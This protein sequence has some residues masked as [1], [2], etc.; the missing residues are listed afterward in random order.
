LIY[1][2]DQ[3][4]GHYHEAIALVRNTT[5]SWKTVYGQ[6]SI[7]EAV[8]LVGTADSNYVTIAPRAEGLLTAQAVNP[9]PVPTR[10]VTL[11]HDTQP[12]FSTPRPNAVRFRRATYMK[13]GPIDTCVLSVMATNTTAKAMRTTEISMVGLQNGRI[14]TGGSTYETLLPRTP[15]IIQITRPSPAMCPASVGEVRAY[16]NLG[17]DIGLSFC[18]RHPPSD[19]TRPSRTVAPRMG[20]RLSRCRCSRNRPSPGGIGNVGT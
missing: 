11:T 15:K 13:G 12:V 5:G 7:R 4:G 18:A 3:Y 10:R 14:V 1:E 17:P 6:F 16:V 19:L 8:S 20:V 9:K 2:P